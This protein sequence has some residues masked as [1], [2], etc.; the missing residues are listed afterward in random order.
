VIADSAGHKAK[1]SG[2][3]QQF[4]NGVVHQVDGVLMPSKQA[5]ANAPAVGKKAGK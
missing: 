5:A 3:D 1:I 2:G 4:S